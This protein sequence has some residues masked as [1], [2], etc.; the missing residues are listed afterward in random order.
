MNKSLPHPEAA[1]FGADIHPTG[2]RLPLQRQAW[3]AELVR[4]TLNRVATPIY[5]LYDPEDNDEPR[6]FATEA[7]DNGA[8][9]QPFAGYVPGCVP[10]SLGN[11]SFRAA[12][13]VRYSYYAGA[14]ANGIASVAM[15]Q[16]LAEAGFLGI[17]GAAGLAPAEVEAAIQTLQQDCAGPFGVNFIHSPNEADL[18]NTLCDLYLRHE[19]RLV[20]ASAFLDLTLP[21]VR[22]RVTGIHQDAEGRTVAPN[23][24]IAKVSRIELARKFMSPPPEKMLQ[25]LVAQGAITEAQAALAAQIPMAED[26]TAEADSGGHTDNRP[27]I[28][29]FPTI[30]ALRDQLQAEYDYATPLR[31][32]LAGGISTPASVAAAFA[33]GAAYV[34]T[35]T[36]NQ[37]CV[38]SGSSDLVRGMLA[39][40]EQADVIMAP[41]ADMFEMGVNVQVLKRGTMFSMR[42]ARLYQLYKSYDSLEALP[43][44][45]R[46]KL[47]KTVFRDSLDNTWAAT[48]DFFL[49]RDPKEVERAERDPKHKMALVFRSY[50]GQASRWA[51]Q[52]VADR[53]IDFQVWCGPAMGA[54]NEWTRDSYLAEAGNRRVAVVAQNLLYG[55]A[56][57]IRL[58]SMRQQGF[59]LPET[60]S[61]VR[62]VTPQQLEE[63]LH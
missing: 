54:F 55:A 1:P 52:G 60:R 43:E 39:E 24:I 14:M 23:R 25:A 8:T 33:M 28:A 17:F 38:E 12:H 29:L 58:E 61:A 50:L 62:P 40:A 45:E 57:L 59:H 11:P 15:V 3:D 37:A 49:N 27:A 20:E 46:Q 13:G 7:A 41:A 30:A 47:E 42:G 21:I 44:A 16:A 10:T 5:L 18:E 22:Y 31:V 9:P 48:R 63:Y 34:V 36:I 56:L 19:V 51:N 2:L 53:K 32:G 6:A 4:D 26:I 35:G